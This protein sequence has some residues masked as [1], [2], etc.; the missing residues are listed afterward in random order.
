MHEDNKEFGTRRSLITGMGIAATGLALG[1]P[2]AAQQSAMNFKPRRHEQDAWLD[3]AGRDHRVFIDS[4]R[5]EGGME[6]VHYADN[7]LN[8][9]RN[10]YGGA[11]EDFGLVVCFRR[12]STPL[13]F[14]DAAWEKYGAAFSDRLDMSDPRTGEPYTSNP[15]N[16]E[17]RRDLP[18]MGATIDAMA[19]RGVRFAV[20]RNATNG[21]SRM[22]A[23]A[24]GAAHEDVFNELLSSGVTNSRF[25]PAGV[26]V[27]TRAQEYGYTLLYSGL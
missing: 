9:H 1:T 26:M 11:Y 7:I 25:V 22:L 27:A 12:F 24:T 8:S 23:Q 19:E 6:A 3:D 14:N 4:A 13:G 17:G 2:A 10:D 21:M 20:C 16:M 18:S 15:L 5:P